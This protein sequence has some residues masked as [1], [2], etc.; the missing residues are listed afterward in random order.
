MQI[1]ALTASVLFVIPVTLAGQQQPS[2]KNTAPES[3]KANAQVTD[4]TGGVAT[5]VNIKIDR[6]T[7]DAERDAVSTALKSGGYAAFL[8]ALR[9]APVVGSITIANRS[10]PIRWAREQ[11]KGGGRH[12]AVITDAPVFF[13]GG[14]APDAKP[15][16]GFDVALLEFTVD[17]IGYGSG[18]MA[19]AARVKAGGPA[20]VE[21]EDYAG[22][23]IT[24]VTVT[25]NLS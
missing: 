21:I 24:L 3:F 7:P 16:A 1:R 19:A 6:Y 13:V 4:A 25:R 22:K 8:D 23:R 14:G 17:S 10:V 18:T 2:W 5:T 11:P 9:K 12:I 20:G 15:T